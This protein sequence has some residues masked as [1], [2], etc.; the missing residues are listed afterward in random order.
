VAG[1]VA[2]LG[3]ALGLEGT[4]GEVASGESRVPA[5]GFLPRL[6]VDVAAP[7]G[8]PRGVAEAAGFAGM[9]VRSGKGAGEAMAGGGKS[10]RICR[11]WTCQ[12]ESVSVSARPSSFSSRRDGSQ[13]I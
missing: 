10:F 12:V 2:V 11:V 4:S 1:L 5:R 13:S 8:L 9:K 3:A 6:A 7:R